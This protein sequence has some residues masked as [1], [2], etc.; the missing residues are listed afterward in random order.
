MDVDKTRVLARV[1]LQRSSVR[2]NALYISAESAAKH[3]CEVKNQEKTLGSLGSEP[4]EP[5]STSG[6]LMMTDREQA[7][8]D[9]EACRNY[10]E[11]VQVGPDYGERNRYLVL[12]FGQTTSIV[13]TDS[14]NSNLPLAMTI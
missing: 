5:H 11:A 8:A 9:F 14:G 4:L 13:N 7:Q 6:R 12:S 2:R 10:T 3:F 1:H